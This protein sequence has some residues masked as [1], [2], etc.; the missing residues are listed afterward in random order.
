VTSGS[1]GVGTAA[2]S[3]SV[4]ANSTGAVRMGTITVGGVAF[5]LTQTTQ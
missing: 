4:A 1:P 5:T 3:F 2:F